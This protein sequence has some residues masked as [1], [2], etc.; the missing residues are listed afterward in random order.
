MAGFRRELFVSDRINEILMEVR[1][2]HRP[3]YERTNDHQCDSA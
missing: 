2:R 1:Q 3:V